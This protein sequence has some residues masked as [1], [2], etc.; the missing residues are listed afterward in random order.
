M[1]SHCYENQSQ[2]TPWGPPGPTCPLNE[3]LDSLTAPLTTPP[4]S[5]ESGLADFV[6]QKP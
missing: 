1:A 4:S 6:M 2:N 3:Y 5:L